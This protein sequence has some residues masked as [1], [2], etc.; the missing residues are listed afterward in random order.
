MT[1]LFPPYRTGLP[2]ILLAAAS[3]MLSACKTVPDPGKAP[4]VAQAST[5]VVKNITSFTDALRCMDNLFVAYGKRDIVITS[6]GLPDQTGSVTAGTKEMMISAISK[7]T[8]KSNAFR[9]VDVEQGGS[10]VFWFNQKYTQASLSVPN[11]YI[12]GAITQVDRSVMNDS[13]SVGF[14]LPVF[15]LGY[16]RDQLVSLMSMDLNMGRTETLQ[17]MP[18]ISSTNTIVIVKSGKGGETEG[19]IQKAS[20]FLEVAADRAQGTHAAV[21]TMIELGLIELLGK[22]TR[23]PYW[24]CLEIES[25]N[26]E[27]LTQARDWY[28]SLDDAA[29]IR[30]AQTALGA[31]GYYAGQTNG[32]ESRELRD[33][34]NRYK[35]EKDLIAN[36]RIDFDLYYRFIADDLA[37]G[38]EKP[39]QTAAAAVPPPAPVAVALANESAGF[40]PLGL[41]IAPLHPPQ[42][43]YKVGD[44]VAISVSVQQPADVYCYYESANRSVA[45]IFPNR[46]EPNPRMVPGQP[47]RIPTEGRFAIALDQAGSKEKIACIATKVSYA[48]EGRPA[49]LR[50]ADLEPLKEVD[51]GAVIYQHQGFDRVRTSVQTLTISVQ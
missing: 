2:I 35:A 23:V 1:A 39:L 9:F 18:G 22:F 29:R 34:I 14:A 45:R 38:G 43:A 5:P 6:D 27:M 15:S 3:L 8:V 26:P 16:S 25:T 37:A 32:V 40:D 47:L 46:F 21:R 4:V 48:N 33:A 12:R 20:I 24:R 17:I 36:G 49:V 7:M 41:A 31:I 44:R 30:M 11:F 10:A 28:D 19:L 42:G 50:Q 13:H 51:L